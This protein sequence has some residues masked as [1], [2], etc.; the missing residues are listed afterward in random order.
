VTDEV[1]GLRLGADDFVGKT[2][3]FSTKVLVERIKVQLRKMNLFMIDIL[4][5]FI[6]KR[7]LPRPFYIFKL[8]I[9]NQEF[10]SPVLGKL[11]LYQ[12][13]HHLYD[14]EEVH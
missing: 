11:Q 2:G 14:P 6:I 12:D 1:S 5:T 7:P 4:L 3:G 8:S 10:Q 13:S 9:L